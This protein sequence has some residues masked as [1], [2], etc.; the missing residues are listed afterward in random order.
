M[1]SAVAQVELDGVVV[2][3]DKF[4]VF[5]FIGQSN[6]AGRATGG[7]DASVF[8]E[9]HPRIWKYNIVDTWHHYGEHHTWV[10]AKKTI[11]HDRN[12]KQAAGPGMAFLKN[13]A[14][15]Y[16]EY[17]FGIVQNAETQAKLRHYVDTTGPHTDILY[18]QIID[19]AI[20]IEGDVTIAGVVAMLG[21]I[22]RDDM[23]LVN[24]WDT[25]M[26]K[27][28]QRM[29]NTLNIPDLPFLVSQYEKGGYG[30]FVVDENVRKLIAKIDNVPSI[31]PHSAVVPTDNLTD[32]KY[33]QDDHHFNYSGHI[34]WAENAVNI[35]VDNS[36]IPEPTPDTQP[37]TA[38]TNLAVSAT[39]VNSISITWT[40]S[41]DD[42]GIKEYE[43]F[44][45]GASVGT[46]STTS[47]TFQNLTQC[48]QHT[49]EVRAKD[50]GGNASPKAS[51]QGQVDC[52]DDQEPPTAPSNLTVSAV[53]HNSATMSWTA[54][55]DNK[56][57]TRYEIY[58]GSSLLASTNGATAATVTGLSLETSYTFTAKA[59]DAVGNISPPSNAVTVTTEGLPTV[60]LPF[61]VNCNG[62]ATGDFAADQQW[63]NDVAYGYVGSPNTT[64]GGAAVSG[65]DDDAVFQS[66]IFADFSYRVR[67]PE[68]SYEITLLFAEFWRNQSGLRV[69]EIDI[70]GSS[71]ASGPVDVYDAVGE[72][73]AHTV[74]VTAGTDTASL[75]NIALNPVGAEGETDPILSGIIVRPTDAF[76][77]L[78]PSPGDTL[79]IGDVVQVQWETHIPRI[80]DADIHFSVNSGRDYHSI[81]LVDA[82][83]D[84]ESEWENYSW[85]IPAQIG[86]ISLAGKDVMLK[87]FDYNQT[88]FGYTD[89]SF[90]IK[91]SAGVLPAVRMHRAGLSVALR[92]NAGSLHITQCNNSPWKVSLTRLNGSQAVY[93]RGDGVATEAIDIA[94]LG[95][96]VY[97][98]RAESAG[99]RTMQRLLLR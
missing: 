51:I 86:G 14:E 49:L 83:T 25:D 48:A 84:S 57:V 98:L 3:R 53:T 67:V 97:L 17:Y 39:S 45:D 75:L 31:L 88:Y 64:E 7:G 19:A 43:L 23:G 89:G 44:L 28:A 50:F 56:G 47:Y 24:A 82:I 11:H 72:A 78:S 42:R 69:F 40:A 9:T 77:I 87:L 27:L 20:K 26:Q 29:R 32:R 94:G 5:L 16:P 65:T 95:A 12:T 55:S 1:S 96:G 62:S 54:A 74:S 58:S 90:H 18:E 15:R 4:F 33:M 38:P 22:E 92:R 99:S 81:G 52:A 34:L 21:I 79:E 46:A 30:G 66:M 70:N 91:G 37:P 13:L 59:K 63:S 35:I 93:R 8:T 60:T 36:W 6:M 68:G 61:M 2:P 73:A 76:T 10:K 80:G 71:P 41:T 85:T